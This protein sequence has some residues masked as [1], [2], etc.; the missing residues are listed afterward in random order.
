MADFDKGKLSEEFDLVC[1]IDKVA[2][3]LYLPEIKIYNLLVDNKNTILDGKKNINELKDGFTGEFN[4][5]KFFDFDP[6]IAED[7]LNDPKYSEI[8]EQM[9][10]ISKN[11]ETFVEALSDN[12]ELIQYIQDNPNAIDA[13]SDDFSPRKFLTAAGKFMCDPNIRESYLTLITPSEDLPNVS[14]QWD[15]LLKEGK[16][17]QQQRSMEALNA[18][19]KELK[20]DLQR[21]L[22]S[23]AIPSPS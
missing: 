13:N 18:P 23:P 3:F 19:D 11:H 22:E 4:A 9:D 12:K 5:K 20:S 21:A 2:P 14:K 8:R 17:R 7:L 10:L 16:L 1:K 15:N 6:D